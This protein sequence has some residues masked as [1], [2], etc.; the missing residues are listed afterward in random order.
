MDVMPGTC[1]TF[2]SNNWQ[3]DV[4][5][6]SPTIAFDTSLRDLL[7]RTVAVA[8]R[9][10][11]GQVATLVDDGNGALEGFPAGITASVNEVDYED[12]A[13]A[14]TCSVDLDEAEPP[15]ITYQFEMQWLVRAGKA[16]FTAH[17]CNVLCDVVKTTTDN[18]LPPVPRD[19]TIGLGGAIVTAVPSYRVHVL[20]IPAS[21][22][23]QTRTV[24]ISIVAGPEPGSA[25]RGAVVYESPN[26]VDRW[27]PIG[28]I[29]LPT[30][31]G[32]VPVN[33]LPASTS[34]AHPGV[35]DWATELEIDLPFGESLDDATHEMIATG[36]N[37]LLV[38]DEIIGFHE[39]ESAGGTLWKVRGLV[40]GMRHTFAAMDTHADGE[41]VVLLTGVGALH[42]MVHEPI[43]GL[44]AANR[45]YYIRVVPAGA[46]IDQVEAITQFV[47][48]RSALPAAPQVEQWMLTQKVG[49][50]VQ[51]AGWG[52]RGIDQTT[53]FGPSP[54]QAGEFERYRVVAFDLIAA[55]GLI[56]SLGID[57]AIA[58]TAKQSWVLG[59]E[60]LGSPMVEKL[61]Q[62]EE[63]DFLAHGFV[64]DVTPIGFVVY[65]EGPFGRSDRSDVVFITPA[66]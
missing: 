60:S 5:P 1:L 10:A 16:T 25:W 38:G 55:G 26:G 51:L 59:G 7:P 35:V 2:R 24:W 19:L 15:R 8:V 63:A 62:Y 50:Y 53:V 43:G 31:I 28:S 17:D 6:A 22:P 12:G 56:G 41:R 11:N 65:Q 47:R 9:F 36:H 64:L 44:G 49:G 66:S 42:G 61:I 54:L 23:G 58:A 21:Y 57:G 27:S 20:D 48:G 13:I 39:A 52:R 45:T 30:V 40:R 3:D 46:S 32:T 29:Q 18:P 33:N 14:L 37:W 4:A 34:G